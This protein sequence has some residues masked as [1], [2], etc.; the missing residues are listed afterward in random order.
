VPP[1]RVTYIQVADNPLVEASQHDSYIEGLVT[2]HLAVRALIPL[3]ISSVSYFVVSACRLGCS[4]IVDRHTALVVDTDSIR[5][6]VSSHEW[7]DEGRKKKDC[8][9]VTHFDLLK[10]SGCPRRD[11]MYV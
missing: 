4:L 7:C 11:L 8:R 2:Y 1:V 9:C 6:K 5:V 3:L 10:E